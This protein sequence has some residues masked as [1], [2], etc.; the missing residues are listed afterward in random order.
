MK[1]L[2]S[3]TGR[4]RAP[5]LLGVA[6][7]SLSALACGPREAAPPPRVAVETPAD[8]IL[9][10]GERWVAHSKQRGLLSPP[11]PISVFVVLE[12]SRLHLFKEGAR[13]EILIDEELELREGG[14]LRCQT[15]LETALEIKWGRREGEAAIEVHRPAQRAARRCVGGQHPEPFLERPASAA[16]YVLRSDN[17]VGV[18]PPREDRVYTPLP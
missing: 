2:R 15:Q 11:S 17:L 10:I 13:E 7:A 4:V 14:S 5:L 9:R 16:R 3:L 8:E 18:E 1:A 12:E 6:A